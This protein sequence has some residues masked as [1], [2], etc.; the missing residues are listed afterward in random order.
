MLALLSILTVTIAGS[1]VN[2]VINTNET[3]VINLWEGIPPNGPGPKGNEKVSSDGSH[4][5]IL[6]PRLI[7]YKPHHPIGAAMLVI[8]GGGY[9]HIEIGKES[10]PASK[11]LQ[12]IGVTAFELVY[13]LPAEGWSSVDVPFQDGQRAMR[14]IRSMSKKFSIDVNKIGIMGFSA[15]GHLAGMIE[16]EPDKQLYKPIDSV[17]RLSARP[18]FVALLYPVI[19]MLP[20]FNNTHAEKEILGTHPDLAQ[21]KKYSVQLHVNLNTPN[22]FLAQSMDDNVSNVENSQLMYRALGKFNISAEIHL[23]ETGGHGWG[24]GKPGT[25]ESTWPKLFQM[26]AQ[27]NGIF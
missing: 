11:W 17:D 9:A 6:R 7:V 5:N 22:T 15:G 24:L 4:T 18:N 27:A 20:P 1:I 2:C 3:P 12:S 13:R 8:G 25:P 16:T 14:L 19:T 26:W 23:F 21:Q 10:T